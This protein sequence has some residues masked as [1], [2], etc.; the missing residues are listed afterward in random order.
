M[1]PGRLSMAAISWRRTG[2]SSTFGSGAMGVG[3]GLGRGFVRPLAPASLVRVC[4]RDG[5]LCT[6][7]VVLHAVMGKPEM[8]P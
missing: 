2:S 1:R 3:G 4:A 8:E 5:A 6:G 7:A